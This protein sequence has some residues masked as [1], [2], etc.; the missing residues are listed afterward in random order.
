MLV[1][2][3]NLNFNNFDEEQRTHDRQNVNVMDIIKLL[4]VVNK[5]LF[6]FYFE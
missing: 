6:R 4:F 2:G 3:Y 5:R 1:N